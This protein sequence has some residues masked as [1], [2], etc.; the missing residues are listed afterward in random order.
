VA[1]H[2]SLYHARSRA[3]YELSADEDPAITNWL[4]RMEA[5][6]AEAQSLG[7]Q[8]L[9]NLEI[10]Y[11]C[12]RSASANVTWCAQLDTVLAM[13]VNYWGSIVA[14]EL[15]DEPVWAGNAAAIN[16]AVSTLRNRLAGLGFGGPGN[17]RPVGLVF[18][19]GAEPTSAFLS[20]T[21]LDFASF[22]AYLNGP[23]GTPYEFSPL[24]WVNVARLNQLVTNLKSR[25]A[26]AGRQ[27]VLIGQSYTRNYGWAN[28]DLVRD[29]Q[30]PP[31][32]LSRSDP[33]VKALELFSY[34]RA[35]GARE[36]S[37]LRV[38]H[39][40][41]GARVLGSAPAQP[42][43]NG[44]RTVAIRAVDAAGNSSWDFLKVYVGN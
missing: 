44:P 7:K 28:V 4:P 30:T 41:I 17:F 33:N 26:G 9:V 37:D 35:S 22:E 21:S 14:F 40:L 11:T 8:V 12:T 19:H 42:P 1:D 34:V 13:V 20:T 36:I 10:P 18:A 24:P 5:G 29:L 16:T 15:A 43:G 38:P 3:Q 39:R 6:I 2:T 32:L 27:V 25:A 23:A 31:Y